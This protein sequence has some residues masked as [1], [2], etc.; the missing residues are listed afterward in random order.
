MA[1][2]RYCSPFLSLKY[3]KTI[4]KTMRKLIL[5]CLMLVADIAIIQA[6]NEGINFLQIPLRE[7]FVKAKEEN[8][9]IFIDCY[10]KTCVPCKYLMKNEFPK[11]ECGDFF[12]DRYI[13]LSMDMDEGD[14]PA[15]RKNYEVGIYPTFLVINPNGTLFCKEEGAKCLSLKISFVEQMKRALDKATW[16]KQYQDGRR[17]TT[18][19]KEYIAYLR[20]LGDNSLPTVVDNYL[21]SI[22]DAEWVKPENWNMIMSDVNDP[23]MTT[24]L[25]ILAHRPSFENALG[26]AVVEK[27]IM[28]VYREDFRMH[29][30]LDIDF[31]KRIQELDALDKAGYKQSRN[32]ADCMLIRWIINEKD[33]SRVDEIVNILV[34]MKANADRTDRMAILKE[35]VRFERVANADQRQKAAEALSALRKGMK[36]SDIAE[37]DRVIRRISPTR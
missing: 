17:D 4:Q 30:M 25:R 29:K 11:K 34:R 28:T 15:V 3:R 32:L 10:I 23:E 16:N 22:P 6:Q 21:R 19:V 35:L 18:F 5:L 9:Q 14:G 31:G 37:I 8:K 36:E 12:N 2:L 33:T 26:K 1:K 7:A 20:S 13:C 27:K 24:F